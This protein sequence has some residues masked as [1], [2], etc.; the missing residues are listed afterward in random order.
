M[1]SLLD[2]QPAFENRAKEHGLPEDLIADLVRRGVNTLN[3]AAYA[4]GTPGTPLPEE[5]LRKLANPTSP[6]TV[7]DGVLAS[8]RRLLFESQTMSLANLRQQVEV[9]DGDRKKELPLE[10]IQSRIKAQKARLR[11]LEL[12][13]ALEVS[14]AAYNL[15]FKMSQDDTITYL[16]LERFGTRAAEVAQ[17]K[18]PKE[19]VLDTTSHLQVRSV[20][21]KDACALSSD[22]AL[23]QALTRRSLAMD[24]VGVATFEVSENWS[25]HLLNHLQQPPPPGY[26]PITHEQVFRADRAAFQVMAE[27]L[28]T[29]KRTA[30]GT[31]PID[32]Q[33]ELTPAI[34]RVMFCLMPTGAGAHASKSPPDGGSRDGRKRKRKSGPS[35][36]QQHAPPPAPHPQS[37]PNPRA[38]R[39]RDPQSF[40]KAPAALAGMHSQTPEGERICWA[41]NL[42]KGCPNGS[43]CPKGKHVCMKPGCYKP[44][45]LHEH[46]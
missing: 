23:A 15:V 33:L 1:A 4:V 2:S 29:L 26:R 28:T 18:T 37:R 35:K 24:L 11:G 13:G 6:A 43:D 39:A 19:L 16:R 8:I 27:K 41:Y 45:P 17:E 14:H 9:G 7:T 32:V 3:K 5:D 12:T 36:P 38:P 20:A 25:R 22:L 44:H 21:P 34:P 30:A 31:L 10:E 40:T 46:K 42:P